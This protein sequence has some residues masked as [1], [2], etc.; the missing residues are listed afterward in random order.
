VSRKRDSIREKSEQFCQPVFYTTFVAHV[1]L[2][3]SCCS[4]I[5]LLSIS[6][7]LSFPPSCLRRPN[8][9]HPPLHS[10]LPHRRPRDTITLQHRP[11]NTNRDTLIL[12]SIQLCSFHTRR[13]RS[14]LA[15]NLEIDAVGVVLGTVGLVG[16]VQ[17]DDF[18]AEDVGA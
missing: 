9:L 3:G 14:T 16:R 1:G 6:T 12:G 18:V 4:T 7:V 2:K 17:S 13:F 10:T 5:L 11:I 8:P 15:R